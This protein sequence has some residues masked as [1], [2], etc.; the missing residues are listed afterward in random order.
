MGITDHQGNSKGVRWARYRQSTGTQATEELGP[1]VGGFRVPECHAEDFAVAL[2]R[3]PGGHDQGTGDNTTVVADIEV[4]RIQPE[5]GK[6]GVIQ[7]PV[8]EFCD[9]LVEVLADPGHA[10]SADAVVI[11]EGFDD[12]VDFAG[13]DPVDPGLADHRV[14]GF[15]DAFTGVEQGGEKRSFPHLRDR[16]VEFAGWG[17][18]RCGACAVA[19][20]GA[21]LV[22]FVAVGTDVGGGFGVDGVL[23]CCFEHAVQDVTGGVWITQDFRDQ[24]G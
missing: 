3:D 14:E 6:P 7:W 9:D 2:G 5:V 11:A 12:L 18:H 23:H 21:L 19:G 13:G 1:E 16:Q 4:G 20:G 17:G 8:G 10:G 22:A 24:C 15:V